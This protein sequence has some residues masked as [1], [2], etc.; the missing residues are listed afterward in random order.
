MKSFLGAVIAALLLLSAAPSFAVQPLAPVATS[1]HLV[2][3]APA[4]AVVLALESVEHVDL[5]ALDTNPTESTESAA[6]I[7]RANARVH[8]PILDESEPTYRRPDQLER[9]HVAAHLDTYLPIATR[10]YFTA[11]LLRT[12]PPY[13]PRHR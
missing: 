6:A 11:P 4:V 9:G 12:T 10:K 5:L 3:A 1:D 13:Q 8:V 7:E 2:T